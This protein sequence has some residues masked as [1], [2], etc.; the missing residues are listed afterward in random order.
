MPV[1]QADARDFVVLHAVVRNYLCHF[2]CSVPPCRSG[3]HDF[4]V[5]AGHSD[6]KA[7]PFFVSKAILEYKLYRTRLNVCMEYENLPL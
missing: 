6:H 1:R 4:R 7:V 2:H 3:S 5:A